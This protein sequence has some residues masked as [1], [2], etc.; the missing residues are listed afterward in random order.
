VAESCIVLEF[1]W[2]EYD[3]IYPCFVTVQ[4][5]SNRI[6]AQG[7]MLAR[8]L[9]CSRPSRDF[10]PVA[11]VQVVFCEIRNEPKSA[12]GIC[13]ATSHQP[14]CVLRLLRWFRFMF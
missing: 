10:L 13:D 2:G 3:K 12:T 14:P 7:C 1:I 9:D 8:V 4:D 11:K 5:H 6:S